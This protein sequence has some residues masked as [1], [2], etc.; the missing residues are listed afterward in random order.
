MSF[1]RSKRPADGV[2]RRPTSE[3]VVHFYDAEEALLQSVASFLA[4]GLLRGAPAMVIM[5][6]ERA[7]GVRARLGEMGVDVNRAEEVRQLAIHDSVEMIERIMVDGMPSEARFREIVGGP[8]ASLTEIW[9]PLQLLAF[10]DMVDVLIARG[11]DDATIELERLW[12]DVAQRV[13]FSVYCAYDAKRFTQASDRATFDAI[14][15]HHSSI[16]PIGV[17]QPMP[18]LP[19]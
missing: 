11:Q 5:M 14:C 15:R 19:A 7:V 9:R 1:F 13:G 8:A 6:P 2:E 3:H 16:V 10:G 4:G 17:G 18:E 12:D